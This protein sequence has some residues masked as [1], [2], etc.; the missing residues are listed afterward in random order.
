M[1]LSKI[2]PDSKIL[3]AV[4]LTMLKAA[5]AAVFLTGSWQ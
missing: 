2:L 4:E 5:A 1:Q 3:S